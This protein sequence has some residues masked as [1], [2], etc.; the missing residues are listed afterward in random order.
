MTKCSRRPESSHLRSCQVHYV[1]WRRLDI[2]H[3]EL[4]AEREE[5]L[6]FCLAFIVKM[7]STSWYLGAANAI[8]RGPQ[9]HLPPP[10]A[11]FK[12]L[13]WTFHAV[14][15]NAGS[16]NGSTPSKALSSVFTF[17]KKPS[18]ADFM[19]CTCFRKSFVQLQTCTQWR[20]TTKLET[21]GREHNTGRA[22]LISIGHQQ[23]LN[24]GR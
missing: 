23:L 18:L 1:Y 17:A 13:H 7:A 19:T 8:N 12:N 24:S 20:T 10:P 22:A 3:W 5:R 6:L 14:L 15:E 9:K 2:R 4:S 11:F 16:Q 21:I